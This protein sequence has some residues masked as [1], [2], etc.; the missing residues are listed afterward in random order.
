[1]SDP[2]TVHGDCY[3]IRLQCCL[4][5][6][7]ASWFGN[8]TLTADPCGQTVLFGRLPDQAAL[9]GVLRKVQE[10]GLTLISVQRCREE[11]ASEASS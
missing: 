9:Q 2:T 7:W 1:M 6:H 3:E 10:L 4:D 11:R 8:M 5:E